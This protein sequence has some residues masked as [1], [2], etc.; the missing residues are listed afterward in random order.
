MGATNNI[1]QKQSKSKTGLISGIT[2][3]T[4]LNGGKHHQQNQIGDEIFQANNMASAQ[5]LSNNYSEERVASNDRQS[6]L[7]SNNGA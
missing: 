1:K 3:D 4:K 6:N 7:N 2:S 5:L